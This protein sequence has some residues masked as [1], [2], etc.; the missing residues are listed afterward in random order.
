VCVDRK[1]ITRL[2]SNYFLNWIY[3]IN[4]SLPSEM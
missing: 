3:K 2:L 4:V 1:G